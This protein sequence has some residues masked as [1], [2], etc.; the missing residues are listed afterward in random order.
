M[1]LAGDQHHVARPGRPDRSGD[2]P[3]P[4]RFDDDLV[5]GADPDQD[6]VD[7]GSGLLGSRVV[8]GDHHHVGALLCHSTHLR[9][10]LYLAIT[11]ATEDHQHPTGP[12]HLASGHQCGGQ[13]IRGV[14][15]VD[16]DVEG[17]PGVHR[18]ES[19]P[20]RRCCAEGVSDVHRLHS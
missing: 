1:T 13:G 9:S 8:R 18:L 17:L 3:G 20:H 15:I 2:G 11:T 14:G 10:L 16:S 7:D 12:D 6:V 5:G 4:V 19:T